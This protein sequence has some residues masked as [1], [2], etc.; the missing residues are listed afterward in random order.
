MSGLDGSSIKECRE[1]AAGL[2]GSSRLSESLQTETL[3]K[4]GCVIFYASICG[5]VYKSI[6]KD[7]QLRGQTISR[8]LC[9]LF[10]CKQT[11]LRMCLS[12]QAFF[13]E[14]PALLGKN[15]SES[16]IKPFNFI[17]L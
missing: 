4:N 6:S 2:L 10:L 13:P 8:A 15:L 5:R 17:H 16:E 14:Y 7:E 11:K 3:S 12:K 1:C 9:S